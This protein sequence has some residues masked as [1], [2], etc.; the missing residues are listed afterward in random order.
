MLSWV[1]SSTASSPLTL[2]RYWVALVQSPLWAAVRNPMTAPRGVERPRESELA[3]AWAWSSRKAKDSTTIEDWIMRRIIISVFLLT[4]ALLADQVVLKNGDRLSG[5]IIKYD[6]K[7]LV[8]KSDL[9]GEVTI[10]W[11]NVT[12]V[13]STQVLNVTLKDGQ[14][15]VGTVTTDGTK[16]NVATKEAGSVT[17]AREAVEY[18]RNEAEEKTFDTEIDRLKNPRLI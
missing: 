9:G 5:N 11:E 8:V 14:H 2:S 15:L 7:N 4:Q 3:G 1:A 18:I 16:F 13:T 10:P 17:A 12:A 6:G